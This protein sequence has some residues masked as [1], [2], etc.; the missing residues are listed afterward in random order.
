MGGSPFQQRELTSEVNDEGCL[1]Q[2]DHLNSVTSIALLF[3]SAILCF[4]GCFL[5]LKDITAI[6]KSL[7]VLI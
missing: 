4:N 5:H 6:S 1:E 3:L 2:P 7:L